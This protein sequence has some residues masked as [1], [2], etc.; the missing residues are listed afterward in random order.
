MYFEVLFWPIKKKKKKNDIVT[1]PL[2]F[3][4]CIILKVN[5]EKKLFRLDV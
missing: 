1:F 2:I 3:L 5:L 4:N